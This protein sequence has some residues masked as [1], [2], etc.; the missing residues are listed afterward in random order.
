MFHSKAA[1]CACSLA[2]VKKF[3]VSAQT[4]IRRRID[5][6]GC[7][8][9]KQA[10]HTVSCNAKAPYGPTTGVRRV[11]KAAIIGRRQPAWHLLTKSHRAAQQVQVAILIDFVVGFGCRLV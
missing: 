8:T 5:R 10:Q 3:A 11:G 9:V 2:E 7:R 1:H 4:Q 6:T